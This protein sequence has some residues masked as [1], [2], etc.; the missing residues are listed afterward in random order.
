MLALALARVIAW[1]LRRKGDV[2]VPKKP[3]RKPETVLFNVIYED[4]TVSSNRRVPASL[5]AEFDSKAQIQ[6]FLEQQ[7]R[8]I[9]ERSGRPRASISR[10]ER[11]R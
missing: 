10:V 11:V 5:L 6:A 9:G 3:S 4:G 7:D 8:E 2:C 1:R